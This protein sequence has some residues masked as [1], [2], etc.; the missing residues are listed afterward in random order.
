MRRQHRN[1]VVPLSNKKLKENPKF[2]RHNGQVYFIHEDRFQ[3]TKQRRW[4]GFRVN[5][6]T[7]YYPEGKP[8]PMD[9]QGTT[10]AI[11]V[12]TENG[13]EPA[14][15]PHNV[16]MVDEQPNYLTSE[17]ADSIFSAWVAKTVAPMPQPVIERLA[18]I[19]QVCTAGGVGFLIWQIMKLPDKILVALNGG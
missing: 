9:P 14:T 15:L 3:L 6:I 12:E 2:F 5:Y 8:W 11:M 19:I 7:Y 10:G 16:P 4:H 18:F 1:A 13:M 17:D